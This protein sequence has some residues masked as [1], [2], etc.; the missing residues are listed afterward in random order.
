MKR[1]FQ[2]TPVLFQQIWWAFQRIGLSAVM[3]CPLVAAAEVPPPSKA[4]LRSELEREQAQR[5]K[6]IQAAKQ[7]VQQLAAPQLLPASPATQDQQCFPIRHIRFSG[8]TVLSREQLLDSIHFKPACLGLSQINT[9]LRLITNRYVAA[10][11]VT[12]RAFLVP[13]DLTTGELKILILEGKLEGLR[14]NGKPQGFLNNAFPHLVGKIL[15]LRDIEQGLDQINR[16]SRYNA[17]IKLLPGTKTGFS[18]VDIRTKTG[19]WNNASFGFNNSGQKST[20]GEAQL[21]YTLGAE[22]I[23]DALDQWSLSGSRSSAWRTHEDSES[24]SL[25][26]DIPRGAWNVAYRTTYSSYKNAFLSNNMTFYTA[27]QTNSHDLTV[28]WLFHRDAISKSSLTGGVSHRREKNYLGDNLLTT[29]SRQ[30]SSAFLSFDYS[31]QLG[32]GFFTL[33]PRF[34]LGTDW[35]GGESDRGKSAGAPQAQFYK[36]TLTTSYTYPVN[37]ALSL[38]STVFGQWSNDKLYGSQQALGENILSGASKRSRFPGMKAITGAM[39]SP[40]N[41]DS[42]LIWVICRFNGRWI[43]A[44]L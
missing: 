38:T 25:N 43:P 19:R 4:H 37:Q 24:L 17:Q 7:G 30:L 10:G 23:F 3:C 31:S 40:I 44:A 32:Q 2:R 20:G 5:L 41:W 29:S 1:V 8:H 26:V 15:N 6:D 28:K 35:F 42:C 39:T 36:G 13:Q 18:I 34:T 27:G 14:F 11:Y 9:Y 22:N 16:L 21:A 12:S 33:S